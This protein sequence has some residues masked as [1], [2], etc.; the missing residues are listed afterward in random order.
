MQ[1]FTWK[2][3]VV[4]TMLAI[5]VVVTG[6][7]DTG[8][9]ISAVVAA[10]V[11]KQSDTITEDGFRYNS[12]GYLYEYTG[13]ATDIV[14]PEGVTGI[15]ASLFAKSNITSVVIPGTVKQVSHY[16]FS[17]CSNL[18][19]VVIKEGV[20]NIG[21]NA[22]E[23]CTSLTDITISD[24]VTTIES[25]AFTGDTA[26]S[27]ISLPKSLNTIGV[28]AF[29]KSGLTS[30]T[31]PCSVEKIENFVFSECTSMQ[32]VVLEAGVKSVGDY[33]FYKNTALTELSLPKT[34]TSI[35][36]HAFNETGLTS[37]TIPGSME[38]IGDYAFE[39]CK[40]LQS[41]VLEDGV[42]RVGQFTFN[43]DTVLTSI[44]FPSNGLEEIGNTAFGH[45]EKIES[46]DI[47]SCEVIGAFAFTSP[48]SLKKL[49]I[50]SGVKRIEQYAFSSCEALEELT[51]D[52][53]LEM[54]GDNAFSTA[55]KL[56]SVEFPNTLTYIG[57]NAF[58]V[59]KQL[60]EVLIPT[61]LKYMGKGAFE[62]TAWYN[63]L[64]KQAKDAGEFYVKDGTIL[65]TTVSENDPAKNNGE[66]TIPN[67]K[68]GQITVISNVDSKA[69]KITIGDGVISV[70]AVAFA[71]L[72][73]LE[74][75]TFADSVKMIGRMTF[76]KC[77][78][79]KKV[80]LPKYI[81][82]IPNSI[83]SECTNLT[84]VNIPNGVKKI[85]VGAFSQ[86][87]SLGK[88]TLPDSLTTISAAAFEK[89][90]ALKELT[91]PAKVDFIG[92]DGFGTTKYGETV[93]NSLT[94]KGYE[95]SLTQA[96]AE[97]MGIPFVSLGAMPND[98]EEE[99]STQA[100]E[101]T[102]KVT[103]EPKETEKVTQESETTEKET[104]APEAT[105][106]VTQTT[107]TTKV[108]KKAAIDAAASQATEKTESNVE[109][110]SPTETEAPTYKVSLESNGGSCEVS[111]VIV[112]NG[113]EYGNLPAVSK[114]N[115]VFHGW[116]TEPEGGMKV[117]NTTVVNLV[118]DQT[119]YAQFIEDSLKISFQTNGG[120]ID[121]GAS[122][123][124]VYAQDVYG[125]LP[126]PTRSG[127]SFIGWYTEQSGGQ[128]I[129]E[130]MQVNA[131]GEMKV[132]AHWLSTKQNISFD[133]LHYSFLNA[134]SSYGYSLPYRIPLSVFQYLY[135]KKVKAKSMYE[136]W[137]DWGGSC[138]GMVATAL[139]LDIDG[140]GIE[141]SDF[142]KNISS[143]SQ[144]SCSDV[145]EKTKISLTRFIET[146]HIA[147][148]ENEIAQDKS[149]NI[150]DL[151][152]LEAAIKA[153][154]EGT[155][156]PV[157]L[158]IH[159]QTSGHAVAAYKI[160]N[161]KIYIYDPNYSNEEQYVSITRNS[162][163][164]IDGWSYKINGIEE[165]GNN[166][167]DSW[168]S[169]YTY[170]N[171]LRAWEKRSSE[172]YSSEILVGCNVPDYTIYSESGTALAQMKNGQ[173]V[174]DRSDIYLCDSDEDTAT[175]GTYKVYLPEGSYKIENTSSS[176]T[177]SVSVM[178]TERSITT[179]TNSKT[180]MIDL[181]D[182]IAENECNITP[183]TGQ[184]YT[185][186]LE[187]T[188]LID[189]DSIQVK[190]T[191]NGNT[192]G[193]EQNQGAA[194]FVNCDTATVT[195]E[196]KPV[197][198]VPVNAS[199][200]VGGTIT[201][202]GQKSVIKGEDA[203]YSITPDTGYMVSDVVV[204]GKSKGNI[205]SYTFAQISGSH[206][207]SAKFEKVSFDNIVVTAKSKLQA[208]VI[209]ELEVKLGNQILT[210][211]DD[212]KVS[213][214]SE[215]EKT[216]KLLI[217]GLGMYQGTSKTVELKFGENEDKKK[218]V[219]VGSVHKVGN[220]K[221]KI[222]SKSAKTITLTKKVAK[223][224]TVTVP[225]TVKISGI[226]FKVT[227]IGANVWKNDK[228]LQSVVIGKNVKKIGAKAFYGAKNLK[229]MTI[230]TT[231]L[232]SVGSGACK[233]VSKKITIKVPA[234]KK[235]AYQKLL[236]KKGLPAKAKWK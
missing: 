134:R 231:K 53:G 110:A 202:K 17:E 81:Q 54:I 64:Y 125:D 129:T 21:W 100:P 181:R 172:Y 108:L 203:V 160:D 124:M 68:S 5:G 62:Y 155:G 214:V 11:S 95:G 236:K 85:G 27:S 33:A 116:Y 223:K 13:N 227:A 228:T 65:L 44:T 212:F 190:G 55:V 15:K 176:G 25:S 217:S 146:L 101:A 32:K 89:M 77:G 94:L 200:G 192:I 127:Y 152:A 226:T 88:I 39:K 205:T 136:E 34:L 119:L 156:L 210:E 4:A 115:C 225:S 59:A 46:L 86:C 204:D 137:P 31:I 193:V 144:L 23:K 170:E 90:P 199:A 148:R 42:K 48:K 35:G 153:S 207:I 61:G 26:L 209:P 158:S 63:Q 189:K 2:K 138:F 1:K 150:D 178:G 67:E 120:T 164:K 233:G 131:T 82:E 98:L 99:K 87:N 215:D 235:K 14:I 206:T 197:S 76:F 157:I 201:R 111:S 52:P 118:S 38:N 230:K 216:M 79:L 10:T 151:D 22:F 41:V 185:V 130:D 183:S 143:N 224:K 208:G 184:N 171:V 47:K 49:H 194:A 162:S 161:D 18:K 133:S 135:G 104:Q 78:K 140:D 123:K 220:Y 198:L 83:F 213:K 163:G 19:K 121:S 177:F 91:V 45:C 149:D 37:V 175:D 73:N 84:E 186:T 222:T 132:Y 188:A 174:T 191:G 141:R 195:V 9:N 51:I 221:Y 166:V 3:R 69:S 122:E 93:G 229:K 30:I 16:C 147:Q 107:K 180:V 106:K 112:R 128:I 72:D 36:A 29:K 196:N 28:F 168:I 102:E 167:P 154:Q 60:S 173:L 40:S 126:K 7:P 71:W 159:S 105:E 74:E 234:G 8:I 117:E 187:S 80:T 92:P 58:G 6:M 142:G 114:A 97:K 211:K 20:E 12:D 75:I 70:G 232:S 109:T 145:S 24:T 56:T 182:F 169:Y 96:Y 165:C 113:N 57:A 218:N 179:N 50:G 43:N 139:M 219:K 103:Q 66:L